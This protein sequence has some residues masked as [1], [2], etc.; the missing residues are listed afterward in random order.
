ML[1]GSKRVAYAELPAERL[2]YSEEGPERG[3]ECG[4]RINLFPRC[5][6]DGNKPDE[7][8]D[9]RA[10]K[11]ELFLWLGNAKFVASCW[12]SILPGYLTTDHEGSLDVF[13][14]YFEYDRSSGMKEFSGRCIAVP[15]VM[16]ITESYTPAEF[17]PKLKW[18]HFQ[19]R[20]DCTGSILAAF[21]LV[22]TKESDLA[23]LP[24][25]QITLDEIRSIPSDIRPKMASYRLEVIFWGVRDMRKLHCVPVYRPRI[26][27][28]CAGVYVKS[29]VME[30]AKK[31]CNFEEPRVMVDLEMPELDMY[32]PSVTIRAYDSRGFGCFKYAGICIVPTIYVFL[33]QLI[34]EE[35]YRAQIYETKRGA[36]VAKWREH[37]LH[38]DSSSEERKG[39]IGYKETSNKGI[40]RRI[41]DLLEYAKRL[42]RLK[43]L[44]VKKE[45]NSHIRMTSDD[46][47]DWWSKYF[48]SLEIYA[49]E[50]EK[51]PEF[52]GFQ[53][54]LST[55]ELWKGKRT[56]NLEN[57]AHGL[58]GKFKGHISV[59]RWPHPENSPCR[60]RRGRDAANG[61]C[62]DYPS[63]ESEKLLVRL[64]VIK[65]INL[66]PKD[67]LNG[68][69][70]PYLCIGLGKRFIND[71]K[72]YIPNQ[73]NPT[74]GRVFEMEATFP[75]DYMLTVQ[76]W[77]HDATSKDDLIGETRIDIENR[78][79]SRHRANC[80]LA[81]TYE[82]SG[83]N[84][85]RDR[86]R[87]KQ[88]LDFL[89]K[90][91]N[92][93]AA[94][95]AE[96]SVRIGKRKFPFRSIVDNDDEREECMAL[97][98]LH[99][100]QEFPICGCALVPEHV[101]RRPLFN[102]ARPGL[103]QGRLELWVDMFPSGNLPPKPVVN[104]A[105]LEPEEY[106]IRVIVW[107]TEDVPLVEN[108]FLT[109]DKCSDIYAKGWILQEDRQRTDV[110]YNS[111]NGEGNFNW[112]FVFRVVYSRSENV[113]VVRK[114]LSVFARNETVEKL[115]CRLHLEVWD[116][117]HF[118]ADDFLGALTLDLSK[119]PRGSA[120][121][122]T[123][124]MRLIDPNLPTVN[125]FKATYLKAWWPLARRNEKGAYVQA[126]KIELELSA[127]RV[128]EA[129]E[130]PAGKGRDP[131]QGLPSPRRLDT[132][133][134][135]FRN[136]WKAC[137][138]VVC[139]YYKW[140]AV[141]CVSCTLL[142]FLVVCAVYA[143]PGYLIKRLV[144]A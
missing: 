22:E 117:D 78:F 75:R 138:F 28:E 1:A 48:A 120:N 103:E 99:Q 65:G 33:E 60:T 69:S 39:L 102:A 5:P 25:S 106:E 40:W 31:F 113:M 125:L 16:L 128:V 121:P 112:R 26:V 21:E 141:L 59:Y 74:F 96:K 10:C 83:Y 73:L 92:L 86:E 105:P 80:G 140:R 20:R 136:P 2:L 81:R 49:E 93:P 27:V 109:G 126:G 115:P 6:G 45:E 7:A 131:P 71:S 61:L 57:D 134:S 4:K 53:D 14:K 89:C 142:V 133:F 100:W 43:R 17:L 122:K 67:P 76:I 62:D 12:S 42:F 79:Y 54:R 124:T 55:F 32:Y 129:N 118:S 107:N 144:G 123:C 34:T 88:I 91:N 97:S 68:K 56:E 85:W 143:L 3:E 77:D 38:F 35:D 47:L 9:Y 95:Y 44:I 127:L 111:P 8:I 94:V 90:K 36:A 19:S 23:D 87:P 139:R 18:Y 24:L 51:Q 82:S 41:R 66:Q 64:Y 119:M 63:Q 46:G 72:N 130:R 98:V 70:D 137:C 52:D 114:K 104:V 13:P 50:L 29:R 84:V 58:A 30:N 101:E 15:S 132:S 110:H 37:P 135:W 116:S 108:Q 11:I